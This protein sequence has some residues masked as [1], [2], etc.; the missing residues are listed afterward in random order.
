MEITPDITIG[1]LKEYFITNFR[2]YSVKMIFSNGQELAQSAW[3]TNNYDDANFEQYIEVL[4]GGRF[5]LTKDFTNYYI[6]IPNNIFDDITPDIEKPNLDIKVMKSYT[7]VDKL[8]KRTVT[9]LLSMTVPNELN[10]THW[11]GGYTTYIK[12]GKYTSSY[13][14]YNSRDETI[15]SLWNS[16]NT[17]VQHKLENLDYYDNVK[18]FNDNLNTKGFT[19]IL[20]KSGQSFIYSIHN[21]E[22]IT[23]HCASQ[24]YNFDYKVP[25]NTGKNLEAERH[26]VENEIQQRAIIA[27]QDID[28]P[29]TFE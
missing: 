5:E 21:P 4:N 27:A 8:P 14:I 17:V 20:M 10:G 13:G 15:Q 9:F 3:D 2:G 7:D 23:L 25:N 1:M 6:E 26:R 12:G 24:Y 11:M 18:D 22:F 28:R 19:Y 16:Y 29:A